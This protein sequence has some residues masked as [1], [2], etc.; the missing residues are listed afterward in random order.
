[1]VGLGIEVIHNRS[2]RPEDNS[3]VERAH[4]VMQGWVEPAECQNFEALQLRLNRATLLQREHYP[5]CAGKTRWQAYPALAHNQRVYSL[6]SESELWCFSR[7]CEFLAQYRWSRKVSKTGQ[8]SLYNRNYG[9]G[10]PYIGQ[11]VSVQ[12]DAHTQEWVVEDVQ[13]QLI[14][15]HHFK[16]FTAHAVQMMQ[17]TRQ[18]GTSRKAIMGA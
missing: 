5:S 11:M 6:R 8:I 10:R 13:G 17:V 2:Y 1:M 12:F 7:V 3:K 16:E 9:V 14:C 15:R 4:G 18:K